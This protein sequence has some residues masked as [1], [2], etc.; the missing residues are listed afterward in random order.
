MIDENIPPRLDL[1]YRQAAPQETAPQPSSPDAARPEAGS[2]S[3]YGRV[4]DNMTF[5]AQG[6]YRR[7]YFQRLW[8]WAWQDLGGAWLG[9][10]RVFLPSRNK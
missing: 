6:A 9:L 10:L 3:L 7:G 8:G 5:H 4:G 2:S 1:Q